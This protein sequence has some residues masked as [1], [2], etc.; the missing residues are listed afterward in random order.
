MSLLAVIVSRRCRIQRLDFRP[1]LTVSYNRFGPHISNEIRKRHMQSRS[2]LL[3]HRCLLALTPFAT[4]MLVA[5][6]RTSQEAQQANTSVQAPADQLLLAAAKVALPPPGVSPTDLPD[7]DSEGAKLLVQYCISCH[8][9]PAP[10]AHSTTDWPRIVRRM[11]LRADGLPDS[12]NVPAPSTA[13]RQ[14]MLQYLIDNSL[15]VT[16]SLPA[17]PGRDFF[18]ATC[19][20]CHDLPDPKQHSSEDWVA[21]VR[22][23]MNRMQTMLDR[24]LTPDQYSRIVLYLETASR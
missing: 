21:V 7:P 14:V 22:R 16:A 10:S 24:T 3:V 1:E 2:P 23:M 13:E 18:E 20:Q 6:T 17:G 5:C 8:N 11:W 4:G 15:Q 9:L 19:S 12:L